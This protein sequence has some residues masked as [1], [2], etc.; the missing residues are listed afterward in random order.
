MSTA[1]FS[2]DS[3][4]S[5]NRR[6][7]CIGRLLAQMRIVRPAQSRYGLQ[8]EPKAVFSKIGRSVILDATGQ[9]NESR[10]PLILLP[11]SE[12]WSERSGYDLEGTSYGKSRDG[13]S[14]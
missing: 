4:D 8:E 5:I 1:I 10:Q 9:R 11:N 14:T 3:L 2:P 7:G 12:A 13:P 6:L